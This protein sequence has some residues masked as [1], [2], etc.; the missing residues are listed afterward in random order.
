MYPFNKF[1]LSHIFLS[2]P[3]YFAVLPSFF[4]LYFTKWSVGFPSRVSDTGYRH[5]SVLCPLLGENDICPLSD[6]P[7]CV[8]HS[9]HTSKGLP[10]LQ[11]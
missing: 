4:F 8:A 5:L 11:V 6:S 9:L 3:F 1:I 2:D 7:Y 10:H